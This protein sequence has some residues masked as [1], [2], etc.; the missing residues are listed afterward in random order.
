M[1]RVGQPESGGHG[2]VVALE[3]DHGRA[4][5]GGQERA[6]QTEREPVD[7]ADLIDVGRAILRRPVAQPAPEIAAERPRQGPAL[8]VEHV[9]PVGREDVGEREGRCRVLRDL[10]EAV[11]GPA[12]ELGLVPVRVHQVAE[13]RDADPGLPQVGAPDL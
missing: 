5:G 3:K 10:G 2:P 12:D 11:E 7:A 8:R 13:Q 6:D 4:A 1:V 9:G